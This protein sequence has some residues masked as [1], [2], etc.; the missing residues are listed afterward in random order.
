MAL[1]R[2]EESNSNRCHAECSAAV[3]TFKPSCQM[4]FT[5]QTN[6][7]MKVGIMVCQCLAV[8]LIVN[9]RQEMCVAKSSKI[10]RYW[11]LLLPLRAGQF[12]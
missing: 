6:T 8:E 1:M 11:M 5:A 4:N 2:E 3:S 10:N 12:P 9:C 7:T